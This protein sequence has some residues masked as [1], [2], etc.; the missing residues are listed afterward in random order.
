MFAEVAEGCKAYAGDRLLNRLGEYLPV[1]RYK[2]G[3]FALRSQVHYYCTA[4]SPREH[5]FQLHTN[6]NMFCIPKHINE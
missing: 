2:A 3:E 4:L 6:Y 5:G 1:C